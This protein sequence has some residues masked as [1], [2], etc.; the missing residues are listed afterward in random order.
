[1]VL[2]IIPHQGIQVKATVLNYHAPTSMAKI[3]RTNNSSIGKDVV[4]L[5]FSYNTGRSINLYNHLEKLAVSTK[6]F[7]HMPT[8]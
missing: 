7:K 4:Q 1:M 3:K 2:N 6:A 8:L 5:E